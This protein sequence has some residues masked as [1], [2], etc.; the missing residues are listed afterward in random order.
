MNLPSLRL[1]YCIRKPYEGVNF[2][3]MTVTQLASE[4]IETN[5][6]I[7]RLFVT[8][9]VISATILPCNGNYV[10]YTCLHGHLSCLP[11]EVESRFYH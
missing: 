3:S 2:V 4:A 1:W 5:D 9:P 7:V 10:R 6:I 8:L 11:T